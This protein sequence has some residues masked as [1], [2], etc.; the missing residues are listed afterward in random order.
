MKDIELLN[1]KNDRFI[2]EIKKIQAER[3]TYNSKIVSLENDN[4]HYINKIR[5]NEARIEDLTL[6]L[7]S[8]LEENISLQ[9][10]FDNYKETSEEQLIR[11]EEEL[12]EAKNEI[13]NREKIINR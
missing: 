13:L 1:N 7:E 6:K 4:D 5:E 12:K 2:E 11:K 9:T 10:D 8:A 3:A